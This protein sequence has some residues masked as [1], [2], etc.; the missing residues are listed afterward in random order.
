MSGCNYTGVAMWGRTLD[1]T[2]VPVPVP[3]MRGR[4][5]A[6]PAGACGAWRDPG[7]DCFR[8]GGRPG[9]ACRHARAGISRW[10]AF[11]LRGGE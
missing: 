11:R 1:E 8:S 5:I 4:A 10:A 2:L 6:L 7:R 9:G 3:P